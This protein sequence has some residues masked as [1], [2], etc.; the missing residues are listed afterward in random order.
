[1]IIKDLFRS[2]HNVAIS[3]NLGLNS[4]LDLASNAIYDSTYLANLNYLDEFS[5][6]IDNVWVGKEKISIV[7]KSHTVIAYKFICY[8]FDI[9]NSSIGIIALNEENILC[10]LRMGQYYLVVKNNLNIPLKQQYA[11][12]KLSKSLKL[13]DKYVY[14]LAI[15]TLLDC[16]WYSK[17][18]RLS[19]LSDKV[20]FFSV[21]DG[22]IK[23]LSTKF[24]SFTPL[25]TD[26][27]D[28]PE[29]YFNYFESTKLNR[30]NNII[31][32][33]L[34]KRLRGIV[35]IDYDLDRPFLDCVTV[36]SN[37]EI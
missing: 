14:N 26:I 2:I 31:E 5:Y 24:V 11:R 13:S 6:I 37:E 8:Y 34:N 1:M 16:S 25:E 17:L 7:S 4:G 23:V 22:K 27:L 33:I 15:E 18:N 9:G 29:D 21:K 30:Y 12:A 19:S 10:F 28:S 20:S 36:V 32:D 3:S 35:S